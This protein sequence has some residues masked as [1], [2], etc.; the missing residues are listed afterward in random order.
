M[1][2]M[3]GCDTNALV[4][5]LTTDWKFF[6]DS[7]K[8]TQDDQYLHHGGKPVVGIFGFFTD[9][10]S[11][12]IANEVLDIFQNDGP[13]GAFVAASGQ[14]PEP[15]EH[16]TEWLQ[17]QALMD[18]YI[19]WNVGN[20]NGEY[21]STAYWDW[22]QDRFS[23]NGV[24]Y[25]PLIYPGFG[26]DNLMNQPPGTTYK[27]RLKGKFMWQQFLDAKQLGAEA[28]YVAMFDEVDESTAIFK[29]TNDIPVNHYF[30]DLEGL[31]SDFYLLLTGYGTSM[32]RGE[33]AIPQDMPDFDMQ[34]QPPIPDILAPQ[35]GDTIAS[36]FDL[37]WSVVNHLSGVTSYEVEIDG[38]VNGDTATTRE[39]E[40]ENGV[41]SFRVRAINGLGNRGGWSERLKITVDNA[42]SID[43]HHARVQDHKVTIHNYPNPFVIYTTFRLT[44]PEPKM[45]TL[46]IYT[47]TGK[48]VTTL[49][50]ASLDSGI[51]HV[52]FSAEG[53]SAGVYFYELT[54]GSSSI[55]KKVAIIR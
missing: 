37:S 33:V 38:N 43:Y 39:L 54:V 9:R 17:A 41:H 5:A 50:K 22:D 15:E 13:Y 48:K 26:W 44:I 29:V 49:V 6:V 52:H 21:A 34:S 47:I 23:S 2:D 31:N 27:S 25:M 55:V 16:L 3:S 10:F 24:L 45:V 18:A 40:L 1:Y 14:W 8:I 32:M 20:Y 4:E 30:S 12:A 53:L 42:L 36:P 46:D 28:V 11:A 19:P 35:Y 7:L 51:H